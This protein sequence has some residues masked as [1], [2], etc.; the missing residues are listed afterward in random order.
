MFIGFMQSDRTNTCRPALTE[1]RRVREVWNATLQVEVGS[2][3]VLNNLSP[4]VD[5]LL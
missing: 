1:E 3:Q 2:A 4:Q 5:R